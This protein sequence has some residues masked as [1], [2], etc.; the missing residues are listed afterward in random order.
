M[1][2]IES[3]VQYFK[4][5]KTLETILKGMIEKYISLGKVG[6][7]VVFN[8]P[9]TQEIEVL[10][11]LMG[12]NLHGQKRI[13]ITANRLQKVLDKSRFSGI[14][15]QEV[16]EYYQGETLISKQENKKQQEEAIAEFFMKIM[17]EFEGTVAASWLKKMYDEKCPPYSLIVQKYHQNKKNAR[18]LLVNVIKALTK[19]PIYRECYEYMPVFATYITKDPHYFDE[20]GEAYTLLKYGIEY[21]CCIK[22]YLDELLDATKKDNRIY[23]LDYKQELFFQVGLL[24][25]D[26]S[27][28]TMVYGIQAYDYQ[29]KVHPGILGFWQER[30]TILLS[31]LSISNLKQIIC[32]GGV[33][34]VVENPAIFIKIIKNRA[35]RYAAMCSSG[36]PKLASL[37]LLD[38]IIKNGGRIYYAGDFD[39]EGLL[40]AD[41]LKSRYGDCLKFWMMDEAHYLKAKSDKIIDA[42][43]LKKL[44]SIENLELKMVANRMREEQVA[45][46]QERILRCYEP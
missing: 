3:C 44:N 36:Q 43:R 29:D 13:T 25:D 45:G 40:I 24:K 1:K 2:E 41:R 31:L 37:I 28:M 5:N 16:L 9:K 27:N 46:Y 19:L 6:G 14:G 34:Y 7:T 4:S 11:G 35:H 32:D 22:G 21:E 10:E 26:I 20:K 42:T 39:P 12:K 23:Q 18:Q 8:D 17:C 38:K 33:I 15:L 30:E